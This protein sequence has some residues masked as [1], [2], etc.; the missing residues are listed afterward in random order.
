MSNPSF[1]NK[2]DMTSLTDHRIGSVDRAFLSDAAVRDSR[3][4]CSR[5]LSLKQSVIVLLHLQLPHTRSVC[6]TK[7]ERVTY[8][9]HRYRI[10]ILV[11]PCKNIQ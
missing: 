11:Y 10:C 5:H 8:L 6:F 7:I 4:G 9:G 1:K 3:P 2:Y